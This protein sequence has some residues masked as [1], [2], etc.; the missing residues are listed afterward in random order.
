MAVSI[1]CRVEGSSCR[2]GA[3]ESFDHVITTC[4]AAPE[5]CPTF[6]GLAQRI[7]WSLIDPAAA[8]GSEDAPPDL[9]GRKPMFAHHR[10]PRE[11]CGWV[12]YEVSG[13]HGR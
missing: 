5:P 9:R 3:G 1:S 13:A 6:S 10:S 11:S 12:P 8:T 2:G 7:S 4:D